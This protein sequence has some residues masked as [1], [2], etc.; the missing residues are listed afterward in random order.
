MFVCV[1][2]GVGVCVG[3]CSTCTFE[4]GILS[5]M[6]QTLSLSLYIHIYVWSEKDVCVYVWVDALRGDF[7][8]GFALWGYD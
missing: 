7:R 3:R 1:C 5:V 8:A 2:V 4:G 6:I